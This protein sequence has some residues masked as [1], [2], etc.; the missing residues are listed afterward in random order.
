MGK[1]IKPDYY[2]SSLFAIHPQE[3]KDRGIQGLLLDIDNT[4][5]PNHMP[6]ADEPVITFISK[7]QES[8]IKMAILSNA[9]SQ[10]VHMFN[11]PLGLP[12]VQHHFKPLALGYMNGAK[13]L[14]LKVSE[15]CMVGDQLFTDI[16]GANRVGMKSILVVPMSKKEPWYVGLKRSLERAFLRGKGPSEHLQLFKHNDH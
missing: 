5:V 9:V 4:L 12:V 3:L 10:R 13:L 6:D 11:R 7:M 16:I 2:I 14:N 1:G 15:V 8:G